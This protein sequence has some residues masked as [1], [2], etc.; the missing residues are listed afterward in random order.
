VNGWQYNLIEQLWFKDLD[1][2]DP[3]KEIMYFNPKKWTLME[4]TNPLSKINMVRIEEFE[5][6]KQFK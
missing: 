2:E 5:E 1:L 3:N 4:Y 6:F